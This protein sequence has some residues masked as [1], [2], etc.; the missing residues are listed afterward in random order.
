MDDKASKRKGLLWALAALALGAL[1]A[2]GVGPLAHAIPRSWE[3]RLGRALSLDLQGKAC[4]PSPSEQALLQRLVERIYPLDDAERAEPIEVRVVR[5]AA[6]NAYAGLGG[7]IT[8]NSGLLSKAGSPE[9]LAGVLAHE[10]EHVRH[11]HVMEGAIVHLF[12]WQG[13]QLIFGG[14]ASAGLAQAL[15]RMDFTKV[16]EAEADK[17]GL[18]RLQ[19]AEVDTKGLA[20]FFE[21]MKKEQGGASFL[22]DHPDDDSR[23][24]MAE[25][26]PTAHPRMIMTTAEWLVLRSFGCG[27]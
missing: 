4:R 13:L 7:Q 25:A 26:Y 27:E 8:V 11:R 9:E 18:Q 16:Q 14:S 23:I 12:S 10:I 20:R 5:E 1:L 21:R 19:K 15:L 22:S 6:V 17:A 2:G 24:A 3:K